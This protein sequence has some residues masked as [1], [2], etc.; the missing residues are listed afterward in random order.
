MEPALGCDS[1][2]STA[3]H[4]GNPSQQDDEAVLHM[5]T[6]SFLIDYNPY[7]FHA[8]PESNC[9]AA[10]VEETHSHR[11]EDLQEASALHYLDVLDFDG[12][13]Q[14][15]EECDSPIQGCLHGQ[16]TSAADDI[17]AIS[18]GAVSTAD[19]TS[20]CPLY[21]DLYISNMLN[22]ENA[23]CLNYIGSIWLTMLS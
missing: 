5:L 11:A 2:T 4:F 16:V 19:T 14:F 9:D 21:S 10:A 23:H 15:D 22:G 18:V 1:S 20:D 8:R 17:M 13:P 6:Q 12:N 7:Y 3:T